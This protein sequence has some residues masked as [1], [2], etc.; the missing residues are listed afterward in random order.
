[1]LNFFQLFPALTIKGSF[2]QEVSGLPVQTLFL[3]FCRSMILNQYVKIRNTTNLNVEFHVLMSTLPQ[4]KWQ[5]IYYE[6]NP[7]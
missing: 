1:M 4:L 5:L 7:D 6:N 2:R 3:Q